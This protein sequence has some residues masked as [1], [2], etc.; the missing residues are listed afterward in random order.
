[1]M[2]FDAKLLALIIGF[3][4]LYRSTQSLSLD[5]EQHWIQLE[6]PRESPAIPP[7]KTSDGNQ[8]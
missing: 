7:G 2:S 6:R 4:L 3:L 8:Q 1:M 5:K